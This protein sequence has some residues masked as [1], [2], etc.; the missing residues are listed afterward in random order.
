MKSKI[1]LIDDDPTMLVLLNAILS[2][3]Y[4]VFTQEGVESALLWLKDGN[5]PH[6]I[7]SDIEMPNVSGMEILEY[8]KENTFYKQIPVIMLS[9][10]SKS[11]DRV[12]CLKKGADDYLVKPF[13]P[14]EL[15]I[16]ISKLLK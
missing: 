14:E 5:M 9:A 1:L 4:D 16:R 13:N 3:E 2:A 7:V 10:K 6:L 11:G 12:E 8:V 15:K